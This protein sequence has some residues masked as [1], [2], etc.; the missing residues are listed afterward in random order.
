V[1]KF[2]SWPMWTGLKLATRSHD[3][4]CFFGFAYWCSHRGYV[5]ASGAAAV[6]L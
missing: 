5:A 6:R 4:R 2:G 1:K 3:A